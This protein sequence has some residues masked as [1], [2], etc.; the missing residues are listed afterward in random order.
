[1]AIELT[2]SINEANPHSA[3]SSQ[4][5]KESLALSLIAASHATSCPFRCAHHQVER[6]PNGVVHSAAFA[7][8]LFCAR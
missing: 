5:A 1:M 6:R 4:P 7:V 2:V 8:S 3:P